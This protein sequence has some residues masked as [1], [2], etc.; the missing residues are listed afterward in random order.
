MII[1]VFIYIIHVQIIRYP[2]FHRLIHVLEIFSEI[3][4]EIVDSVDEIVH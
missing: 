3:L 2:V 4:T 1:S